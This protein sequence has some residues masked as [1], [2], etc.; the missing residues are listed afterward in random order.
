VF[1]IADTDQ[2]SSLGADGSPGDYYKVKLKFD[3]FTPGNF[4]CCKPT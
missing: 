1:R 2:P 4:Q 3:F